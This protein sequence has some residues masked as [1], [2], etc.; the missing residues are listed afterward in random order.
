MATTSGSFLPRRLFPIA[1]ALSRVPVFTQR[2][3]DNNGEEIADCFAISANLAVQGNITPHIDESYIAIHQ[4]IHDDT[5]LAKLPTNH[6]TKLFKHMWHQVFTDGT[7]ILMGD[8]V[9]IPTSA[10]SHILELLQMPHNSIVKM[11][12]SAR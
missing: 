4:A 1:D 6:P 12:Q 8:R 11:L 5:P 3:D 7:L 9:A 2:E 10:Q